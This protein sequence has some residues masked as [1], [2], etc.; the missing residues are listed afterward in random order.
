MSD[1]KKQRLQ[2]IDEIRNSGINPYPY[3]FEKE[4]SASEIKEKYD[5]KI[6]AGNLLEEEVF[7]YAGRVMTLR[8]HGKSAFL[9]IKD[10]TGRLQIY[11]RKDKLGDEKYEFFKK[12]INPGDWIGVKGFPFKTRTGELTILATDFELLTKSVRP[13]PEKWHGLKDKEIRYRQRYVDMISNDEVIETFRNRSLVVRYIRE[14]LNERDFFEVETPILQ[15]IMGGANARPFI[16]HLNVYDIPMYLRIATELHLKRLVVGGM[17]RVYELGRIFR[18]EGVDY[19]HNPEF[20]TI[21]LYQAYADYNDI[22]ELTEN[23][24]AYVA[25]KIH[26]TTK[27]KYGELE[28]DFKPPF[29]RID[30]REFIKEHLGVDILEDSIE[31]MDNYLKSKDI[32]VEIKERGKYIDE[33]WDLVEDKLVQPTFIMNH[34]VEISPL[35]KRHR[36]DPRL[37]ERFELIVNGTELANAFSELN[38][39]A[40]QYSRFKA[41]ADLKDLGDE[42]AQLM[43]LDF[44][45]ALE[46]GMPPTGGLGIG[47]DRFAMFMTNTQTIKDIIPFP[48]SKP[49]AFEMEEAMMDESE[50]EE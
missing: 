20:T 5:E 19:K 1:L 39:A 42:E 17:E 46:Y 29:K 41:Q 7:K 31:T 24:L 40:D 35:A 3:K 9:H 12:Y 2:M 22:M 26:G 23:L 43:D 10:D 6:E 16:T 30:M 33:L 4:M 14:Y 34:P 21:E 49:M 36:E 15:N 44:V 32:N 47:I 38:D 11:I 50:K 25:E 28:I 18:N 27:I 45:R 8:S 13:M 48:L 37:T